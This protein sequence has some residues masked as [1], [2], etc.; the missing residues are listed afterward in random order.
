MC[1]VSTH[2]ISDRNI[3]EMKNALTQAA[4]A[5]R[6]QIEMR[7]QVV[8]ALRA[9]SH[10]KSV[11]NAIKAHLEK[12][13]PVLHVGYGNYYSQ[14]RLYISWRFDGV[15]RGQCEIVECFDPSVSMADVIDRVGLLT[16]ECR[17]LEKAERQLR[18]FEDMIDGEMML[19]EMLQKVEET[20]K[21]IAMS[22][23]LAD[24]NKTYAPYWHEKVAECLPT[25]SGRG[26]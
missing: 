4:T 25:L 24:E 20:R 10:H 14:K 1:T 22:V 9:I 2:P 13:I 15:P 17:Q 8:N 19:R 16:Y 5:H 3:S 7:K 21:E 6:E 12:L 11:T 26:R 18:Y 23:M